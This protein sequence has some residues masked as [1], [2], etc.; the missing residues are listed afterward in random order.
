M[1]LATTKTRPAFGGFAI[2]L[3][4][5][6]LLVLIALFVAP[7]LHV[8]LVVAEALTFGTG[9]AIAIVGLAVGARVTLTLRALLVVDTGAAATLALLAV[10]HVRSPLVAALVDGALVAFAW[11]TGGSIG[12]RVEDAGHLV[13]ACFVAAAADVASVASSWGPSHA[14]ASSERALSLLAISAPVAGTRVV[15][16]VLGVGDL[17]F[18]ALM[19]GVAAAKSLPYVRVALL[20]AVGIALAGFASAKLETAVP[21]LPAIG[22]LVL[23]GVPAARRVRRKDRTV[24]LIAVGTSIVIAAWAIVAARHAQ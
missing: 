24:T 15:A 11:A 12:R 20:A 5:T 1:K 3:L 2:A 6:P 22:A 7:H 13:A 9:A 4:I 23:L 17:V 19:L 10:A 14:I 21:A 18:V 16:P 8:S